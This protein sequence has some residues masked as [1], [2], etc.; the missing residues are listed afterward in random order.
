MSNSESTLGQLIRQRRSVLGLSLYQLGERTGITDTT[1][2][3]I[4]SGKTANPRGEVLRALAEALELPLA[5]LFAAAGYA[6]PRELPSFR[7][8]LRAKYKDLPPQAVTELEITFADIA[9]RYG[10]RGPAPGE[11]EQ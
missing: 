3:R 9:R 7:P 11:D 4:E 6:A 1:I 10:T 2:M 5:D 8:Y